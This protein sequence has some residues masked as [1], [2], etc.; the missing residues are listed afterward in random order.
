MNVLI[1]YC[2]AE[3]TE[4]MAAAASAAIARQLP[5]ATIKLDA[6]ILSDKDLAKLIV[7]NNQPRTEFIVSEAN[8]TTMTVFEEVKAAIEYAISR[9]G[10][11]ADSRDAFLARFNKEWY[12]PIPERKPIALRFG[13]FTYPMLGHEKSADM[14]SRE[15]L[16]SCVKIFASRDSK[17]LTK[18]L[19]DLLSDMGMEFMPSYC[20][21]LLR[22]KDM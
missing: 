8:R 12:A 16:E 10:D 3:I 5:D 1:L 20:K 21:N 14:E 13:E 7:V 9:F 17:R 2:A 19:R 11:P 6:T 18:D 4:S 15:R 22:F